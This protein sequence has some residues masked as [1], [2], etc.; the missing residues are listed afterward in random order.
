MSG[1]R[2]NKQGYRKISVAMMNELNKKITRDAFIER[3][4]R[5]AKA[6]GFDIEATKD[7]CVYAADGEEPELRMFAAPC[8]CGCLEGWGMFDAED[9]FKAAIRA[10]AKYLR[11]LTRPRYNAATLGLSDIWRSDG[12]E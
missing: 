6:F 8:D 5:R 7:G 3:Y 12:G 10:M 11:T 1:I 9:D 2:Y 4:V